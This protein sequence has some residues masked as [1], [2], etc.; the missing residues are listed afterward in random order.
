M[1][2]Y[3]AGTFILQNG[4]A[5]TLVNSIATRDLLGLPADWLDR[6]VPRVLAVEP[7]TMRQVASERFPLEKMTLVVVGDLSKIT[8]QL[9][10][11]PELQ[12]AT[13]Q[14]ASATP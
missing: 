5:A 14:T 12:N 1:R 7:G 4:S 9:K 11:L 3:L 13:F 6:Y 10:A 8:P 2:Q